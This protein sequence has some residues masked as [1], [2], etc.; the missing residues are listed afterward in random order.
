MNLLLLSLL[1]NQSVLAHLLNQVTHQ[2]LLHL[3]V[4]HVL[5]PLYYLEH[6]WHHPNLEVLLTLEHLWLLVTL[7]VL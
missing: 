1:V 6:L 4:Q 2:V 5:E 3:S 7:L